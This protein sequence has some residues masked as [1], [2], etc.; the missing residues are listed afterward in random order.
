LGGL[1]RILGNCLREV[2]GWV[3]CKAWLLDEYFPYFVRDILVR[4]F[5]IL[6][7]ENEGQHLREYIEQVFRAAG[8]LGYNASEQQLVDRIIMNSHPNILAHAA[9]LERPR[10]RKE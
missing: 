5:I 1:L 10:S 9:F 6:R 8:F 2:S 7:F 4:N 3:E